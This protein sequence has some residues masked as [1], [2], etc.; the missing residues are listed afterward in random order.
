MNLDGVRVQLRIPCEACEAT[1][2]QD[3]RKRPCQTCMGQKDRLSWVPI[4]V[5]CN[6]VAERVVLAQKAL[7]MRQQSA[8]LPLIGQGG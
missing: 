5:F 1:G 4:E 2:W 3:E 8:K 7:E 6:S